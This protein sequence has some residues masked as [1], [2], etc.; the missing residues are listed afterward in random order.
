[1]VHVL[2]V[3]FFASRAVASLGMALEKAPS[4]CKAAGVVRRVPAVRAGGDQQQAPEEH[5]QRQPPECDVQPPVQRTRR[6]RLNPDQS[7][8]VHRSAHG[9]PSGPHVRASLR[10]RVSWPSGQLA[11]SWA[12]VC[13]GVNDGH[14]TM[15][16]LR[17]AQAA[18]DAA[19][20]RAE[21][22]REERNIV[23]RETLARRVTAA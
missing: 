15:Q 8:S 17:R 20:A 5:R 1:V 16:R 14:R 2:L 4:A 6:L 3:G 19:A 11:Q 18:I 10:S 7:K 9:D 12:A 22:R 13:V 21:A 23:V